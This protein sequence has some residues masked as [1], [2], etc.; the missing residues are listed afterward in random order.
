MRVQVTL[1]IGP[2]RLRIVA[3]PRPCSSFPTSIQ[4]LP[5]AFHDFRFG[6]TIISRIR[7]LDLRQGGLNEVLGIEADTQMC[8]NFVFRKILQGIAKLLPNRSPA[9]ERADQDLDQNFI[10]SKK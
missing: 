5:E 2:V 1:K 7:P 9:G 10:I 4:G 6:S 3:I 8:R